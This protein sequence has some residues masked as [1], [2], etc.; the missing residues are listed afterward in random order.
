MVQG[1]L[2]VHQWTLLEKTQF[3]DLT[4]TV[5]QRLLTKQ[6]DEDLGIKTM[7]GTLA[8]AVRRR[9]SDTEKKTTT[10]KCVATVL[11]SR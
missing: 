3:E 9:F 5:L 6:T 4:R 7:K 2:T 10:L 11:D 8:A 1:D